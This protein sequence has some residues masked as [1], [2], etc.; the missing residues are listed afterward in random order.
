MDVSFAIYPVFYFFF[1]VIFNTFRSFWSC[2][3]FI[4]IW[5]ATRDCLDKSHIWLWSTRS[6]EPQI[7]LI[8]FNILFLIVHFIWDYLKRQ[9]TQ[10]IVFGIH[11][12]YFL[13]TFFS[14]FI[15]MMVSKSNHVLCHGNTFNFVMPKNMHEYSW[16][17]ESF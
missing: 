11:Y 17:Y 15:S 13:A 16:L 1:P 12:N 9:V 3:V 5:I 7:F 6:S 8:F 10:A 4:K 2:F 14:N